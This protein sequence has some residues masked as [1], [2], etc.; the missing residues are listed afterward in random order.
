M[1][2]IV[3]GFARQL[4]DGGEREALWSR[5][6]DLR[7]SFAQVD[8]SARQ[9]QAWLAARGPGPVAVAVGNVG[10]F[11]HLSLALLRCGIPML[12]M[13]ASAPHQ[14]KIELCRRLGIGTLLHRDLQYR[15]PVGDPF[16]DPLPDGVRC[17][18]VALEDPAMA[19]EPPA[20]TALIK[21]TSGSTGLPLGICLSAEAL[22]HGIRHIGDGMELSPDER[23]LMAIPLSHSYG[24]DNGVLSLLA[25][26]TPLI[27][28]PGI[29][30]S[31]LLKA[32][33]ES[34]ATFMPLVP[35]L[36]RS[37]GQTQW[38]GDLA[39]R[40]VIC[41][42]GVLQ[43][44]Q[45]RRF[46]GS[47]GRWV[48]NFYGSTETGGITFETAPSDAAAC[49]TVGFPLPGVRVDIDDR[50]RVTVTSPANLLGYLGTPPS[51][52]CLSDGRTVVTGDLGEWTPEGR[53]RLTGRTA[54]I[55][56]IGGRKVPAVQVEKALR[57]LP[58]VQEVAVVGVEDAMRGDR[59]V[60]FVVAEG[61]PVDTSSL[62]AT[63]LPREMRPL[64]SL[65][66]NERGKVD[67]HR[68]RQMASRLRDDDS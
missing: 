23:V 58:G 55:L 20:D 22:A 50:G 68:L 19:V 24:F 41:A 4:R 27:L 67:R 30:P 57:R 21:L 10:A 59:T 64:D 43:E 53:L 9:W 13:D 51:T 11:C 66:H 6:E 42:G 44:E 47:T 35:P 46:H 63:L 40:R 12:A 18:Q 14:R 1:E 2:S 60:A 33:A 52:G 48:Q 61:W 25:L 36:V 39:L 32:L 28:E 5:G 54:D 62:P 26:G 31:S 29:F 34:E 15:D 3:E 7:Q 38:P 45:A 49:G 56:N 8:A 65:P 16:G 17:S 37:L